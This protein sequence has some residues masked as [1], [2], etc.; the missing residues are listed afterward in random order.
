M[1]TW[2][3]QKTGSLGEELAAMVP[4]IS[5]LVSGEGASPAAGDATGVA[6]TELT[7]SWLN[8]NSPETQRWT[9]LWRS[10]GPV[11]EG[12]IPTT[13]PHVSMPQSRQPSRVLRKLWA[14]GL[15]EFQGSAS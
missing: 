14:I 9:R 4:R 3:S 7:A 2:C 8:W 10:C 15:A 6:R 5:V 13:G 1:L 12:D 11:Q